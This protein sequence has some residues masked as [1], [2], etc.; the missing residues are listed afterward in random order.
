MQVQNAQ[1]GE[2][3]RFD[4]RRTTFDDSH[5]YR[6]FITTETGES[7]ALI[8]RHVV[9]DK[10]GVQMVEWIDE[11]GSRLAI[12]VTKMRQFQDLGLDPQFEIE[13]KA[14]AEA[15]AERLREQEKRRAEERDKEVKLEATRFEAAE[16]NDKLQK[17]LEA[18]KVIKFR[19]M[20][21][22]REAQVK[23]LMENVERERAEKE[24]RNAKFLAPY[25]NESDKVADFTP[26]TEETEFSPMHRYQ[27]QRSVSNAPLERRWNTEKI[28]DETVTEY[29]ME[30]TIHPQD[31]SK[32]ICKGIDGAPYTYNRSTFIG[33]KKLGRY[34]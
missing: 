34:V 8:G 15:Q 12:R 22:E 26:V 10:R 27:I 30:V 11:E 6:L 29:F 20:Q 16:K 32:L 9:W 23:I 28:P 2:I 13:K 1:A 31:K 25:K 21:A 19:Q 17:E 18:Q 5:L 4:D 7:Q 24:A 3:Q 33:F 14:K